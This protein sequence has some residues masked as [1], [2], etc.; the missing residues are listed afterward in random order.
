M[1][2]K[3]KLALRFTV[4]SFIMSVFLM[5]ARGLNMLL[6]VEINLFFEQALYLMLFASNAGGI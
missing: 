2:S 3:I 5:P 4:L 1:C 6:R